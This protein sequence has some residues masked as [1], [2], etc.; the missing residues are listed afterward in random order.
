ME[1]IFRTRNVEVP[2]DI[3]ALTRKKLARLSRHLDGWEQAEVSFSEER[4]PRI[5]AKEVCEVTLRG[6]GQVL[7][8]KAATSDTLASVDVVLD[9]LDHQIEALKGRL[10]ARSH[11]HPAPTHPAGTA[12]D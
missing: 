7:R 9:K 2:D 8:A 12:E 5:S 1:V 6:H 3:R 4:N 11:P 10:L